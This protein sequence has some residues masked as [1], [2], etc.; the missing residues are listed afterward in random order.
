MISFAAYDCSRARM[1]QHIAVFVNVCDADRERVACEGLYKKTIF[2]DG[3]P[4]G[5]PL[6]PTEQP[7]NDA[8]VCLFV[9]VSAANS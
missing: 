9:R 2:G 3:R 4:K 8:R 5:C 7:Q 6:S 1:Q